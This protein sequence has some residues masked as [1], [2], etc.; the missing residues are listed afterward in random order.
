MNFRSLS[1]Q[2]ILEKRGSFGRKLILITL[3]FSTSKELAKGWFTRSLNEC[4]LIADPHE[5][6]RGF[7]R[8]GSFF[9]ERKSMRLR[10][11]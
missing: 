7:M 4:N 5:I 10:I 11:E 9:K 6:D 8:V 1:L 2:S 3:G